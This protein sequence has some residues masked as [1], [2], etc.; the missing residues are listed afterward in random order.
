MHNIISKFDSYADNFDINEAMIRL[1]FFH[2]YRVMDL[3]KQIANS[4][5]LN[6]ED[7]N[8]AMI[9]GLLHDYARFMQ[10]TKYKTFVDNKSVDH[11]DYAVKLLFEDNEIE[12]FNIDK[13][14]YNYIYD[15]I[16]YHNK[17]SLPN[18][19]EEKNELFC[20]I[21]K[22]ADKLDIFY[23]WSI[24]EINRQSSNAKISRIINDEFYQN[25]LLK[26]VDSKS[27]DDTILVELAMIYDLN[28]EFSYDYLKRN[29]FLD[30]IYKKLDNPDKFKDYFD[31]AKEYVEKREKSYVR[32]KI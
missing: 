11:G 16:K 15:A 30:S 3:C 31:Y 26:K 5:K 4:L 8:I 7:T 10:W 23:L 9:I 25:K 28:F 12:Q 18:N 13:K 17:Y 32:K 22:D 20:K 27:S 29:R 14:Y 2:S 21:I 1:K 19:L 6:D 24:G